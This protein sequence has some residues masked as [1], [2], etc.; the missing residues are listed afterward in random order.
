MTITYQDLLGNTYQQL[1]HCGIA[2]STIDYSTFADLSYY[3]PF[4]H[5]PYY[6]EQSQPSQPQPI[7]T[8]IINSKIIFIPASDVKNIPD[9]YNESFWNHHMNTHESYLEL[10][11]KSE[12]LLKKWNQGL[13][14]KDLKND[15]ECKEVFGAYLSEQQVIKVYKHIDGTY[16]LTGDGRHRVAAAQ[17]LNLC[18]PVKIIGEY[19]YP[20]DK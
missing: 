12:I 2:C 13:R 10:A 6:K 15:D 19:K 17:E 16:S 4:K 1:L 3:E 5:I 11:K 18:I 9:R 8:K 14:Y 7:L 20:Y